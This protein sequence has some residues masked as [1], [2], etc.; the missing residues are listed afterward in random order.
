[1]PVTCQVSIG[2]DREFVGSRKKVGTGPV[3]LVHHQAAGHD[4]GAVDDAGAPLPLAVQTV[5]AV[6]RRRA[7]GADVQ[8]CRGQHVVT[9]SQHLGEDGFRVV[10]KPQVVLDVEGGEP[11]HGGIRPGQGQHHVEEGVQILL[12][13]AQLFRHHEREQAAGADR[14]DHVVERLP[15]QS[16]P[17]G[18]FPAAAAPV[19]RLLSIS[20]PLIQRGAS[21]YSGG[22]LPPFRRP[23]IRLQCAASALRA[24]A[25]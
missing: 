25:C 9:V 18:Q 6:D 3:S 10:E 24:P 17:P 21:A 13:P 7:A 8:G 4:P 1:M 23:T 2:L 5:T 22:R 19:T 16:P 20:S 15:G 11:A 12:M 14:I